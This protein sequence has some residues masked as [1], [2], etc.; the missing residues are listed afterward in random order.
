MRPI[1]ILLVAGAGAFA[2][3]Q[4]GP[5]FG[6]FGKSLPPINR[7]ATGPGH[8]P[9]PPPAAHLQYSRTVIVPYPVYYG[10]YYSGFDAPPPAYGY[11]YDPSAQG[12]AQ[13]APGYPY[14][15]DPGYADLNQSPVVIINQ[16]YR[17]DVPMA[18]PPDSTVRRYETP[19][20]PYDNQVAAPDAPPTIYLVAMKDHTIFPAL[21][22][23]VEGD[24]LNYITTE[25]SHNRAT[26]DL[27]DREFSRQLN[28]ER[29]VE[30]KLPPPKS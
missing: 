17:P 1:V 14:N 8:I 5:S 16:N 13:S 23:W 9:V 10:G 29:H 25:G 6:S 24:T 28:E 20:H 30:F 3:P 4:P 19:T 22:Y 7:V 27:V 12:Y 11:G 18:P 15:G 2:Q 26:L 21:A